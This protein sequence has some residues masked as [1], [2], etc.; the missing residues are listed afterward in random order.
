LSFC[1]VTQDG[2]DEGF[3]R[4]MDLPTPKQAILIR[5]A[6]GL[7]QKRTANVGSFG[8]TAQEGF[9]GSKSREEEKPVTAPPADTGAHFSAENVPLAEAAE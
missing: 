6:L 5:T 1:K 3:L 8:S 9:N 4:L 2:D 7:K